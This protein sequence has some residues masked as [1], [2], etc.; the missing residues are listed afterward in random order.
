MR[1]LVMTAFEIVGLLSLALS[2]AVMLW[3]FSPAL[4]LASFGLCLLVESVVLSKVGRKR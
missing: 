4:S 2:P 1:D 3:P